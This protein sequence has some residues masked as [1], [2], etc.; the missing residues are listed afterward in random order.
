ME[1][2]GLHR[3]ALLLRQ[4]GERDRAGRNR[5]EAQHDCPGHVPAE[6]EVFQHE[7]ATQQHP[8]AGLISG[9]HPA[10]FPNRVLPGAG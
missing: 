8:V 1:P 3:L 2:A 7:P 9:G 10:M 5:G 6:G 4:P